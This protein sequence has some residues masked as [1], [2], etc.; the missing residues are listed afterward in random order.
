[1]TAVPQPSSTEVLLRVRLAESL[2][3]EDMN[4]LAR[5][6]ES[7]GSLDEAITKS[8]KAGLQLVSQKETETR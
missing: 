6:A 3:Q 2:T 1:M 8:L 5:L 7:V 4:R